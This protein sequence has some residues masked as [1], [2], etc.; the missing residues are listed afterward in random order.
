LKRD[1][2]ETEWKAAL[3]R[4]DGRGVRVALLDSGVEWTHPRLAGLEADGD[5]HLTDAGRLERGDGTDCFGH[6]TAVAS[7][8]H[9]TARGAAIGS[10]RVLGGNAYGRDDMVRQAALEAVSR[11]YD[12]V[13][14]SCGAAGSAFTVMAFKEWLDAA[15]VAGVHVVAACN[16]AGASVRVWPAHFSSVVAVDAVPG[17]EEAGVFFR[18]KGTM[19]E[20][21]VPC[22]RGRDLAWRGGGTRRI[23]GTSFCAPVLTGWMARIL[24]C[25]PGMH[26]DEM[27]VALRRLACPLAGGG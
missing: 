11:G 22:G 10:F 13:H 2:A 19:V 20:F 24:S 6:G 16:N 23:A 1:G 17:E 15:W 27:R 7:V 12:I 21:A 25:A 5:F 8:I 4:A 9:D 3:E 18:R 26:P 14:C